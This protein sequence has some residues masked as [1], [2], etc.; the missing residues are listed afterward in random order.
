MGVHIPAPA[1][2]PRSNPVRPLP[3]GVA[4]LLGPDE[5]AR[6]VPGA[7][8]YW[9]TDRGRV[10]STC[11]ASPIVCRPGAQTKGYTQVTLCRDDGTRWRPLVHTIVAAAFLNPPVK[12]PHDVVDVHHKNGHKVDNRAENLEF[13]TREDHV[14]IELARGGR[15]NQKAT[16]TGVWEARCLALA[17][18][19]EAGVEYLV[20]AFG[21]KR[22]TAR[23]MV[24]GKT[25]DWVPVPAA[26][27]GL[28]EFQ[29]VLQVTE[30]EAIRLLA[31]AGHRLAA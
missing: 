18:G 3:I 13:V 31:M 15:G 14:R 16:A 25:W 8:R 11:A 28:T 4:A 22:R 9:V 30:T 5:S 24:R 21:V 29:R 12:G 1:M 19:V 26:V 2:T 10:I 20:D 7:S 17:D 27:V 6:P 23:G